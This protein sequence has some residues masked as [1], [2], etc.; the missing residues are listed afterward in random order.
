MRLHTLPYVYIIAASG[1]CACS[2]ERV[3]V[4]E[5]ILKMKRRRLTCAPVNSIAHSL[6]QH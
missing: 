6:F 1:E 3:K 4:A 5:K 2:E